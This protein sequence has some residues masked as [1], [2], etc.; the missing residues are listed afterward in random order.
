MHEVT[1]KKV[2]KNSSGP[3]DNIYPTDINIVAFFF[4]F[5]FFFHF[6]KFE[7][8]IDFNECGKNGK[9]FIRQWQ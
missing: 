9:K 3:N 8:S 2:H 7:M 6:I 1:E 4:F 5:F